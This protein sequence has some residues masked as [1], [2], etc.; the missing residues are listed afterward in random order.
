[1]PLNLYEPEGG[2]KYA[3]AGEPNAFLK[4]AEEAPCEMRRS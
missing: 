1:M 4:V 3:T 2:E